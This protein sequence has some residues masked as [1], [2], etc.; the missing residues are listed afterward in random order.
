MQDSLGKIQLVARTKQNGGVLDILRDVPLH[1]VIQVTGIVR[2][3]LESA[4]TNVGLLSWKICCR[5]KSC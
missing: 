5:L 3:R 1:S 4:V 2:R